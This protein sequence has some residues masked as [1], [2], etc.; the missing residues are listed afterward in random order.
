MNHP[1]ILAF[2][3]Q[4]DG[5][6]RADGLLLYGREDLAERNTTFEV[7]NYV[8]GYLLVGDD[9][10]G[11]GVL[12]SCAQPAHPV[13]ICGLGALALEELTPLSDSLRLW[14]ESGCPLPR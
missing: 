6:P 8:P 1:S 4:Q 12:V 3:E 9:S 13:H 5:V 10:G 2:V 11:R 7:A 14:A